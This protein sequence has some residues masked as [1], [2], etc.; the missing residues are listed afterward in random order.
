M[1]ES[2]LRTQLERLHDDAWGWALHCSRYHREVAEDVLQSVYLNILDGRARFEGRS[3][4]RTWLFAVIRRTASSD[5]RRAWM[6]TLIVARNGD[7][8]RPDPAPLPDAAAENGDGV[9]HLR[10][11]LHEL[12]DRQREVLHLVFYQNLTIE[13]AASVMSVSVGSAR[14]HYARGKERLARMLRDGGRHE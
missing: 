12:S 1:E 8:L 7:R 3:S 13:E 4:F 2:E 10:A 11:A 6:R 14:V 9:R 5:R